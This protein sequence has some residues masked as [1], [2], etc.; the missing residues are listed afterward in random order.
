MNNKI[1]LRR[2]VAH[3]AAVLLYTSQEKEY[4]QAKNK[5]AQNLGIRVLPTNREVAKE[6]DLIAEE[7]EGL[8]RKKRL[9]KL[10]GEALEIMETL[11]IFFPKIVG[12]VWRGTAHKNSD[13]DI[14]A[15]SQDPYQ[16]ISKLKQKGFII[17]KIERKKITNKGEK[18]FSLHITTVFPTGDEAE[19][20]VR[21]PEEITQKEKCEIYGD[22]M[23]GLKIGQL[24]KVLKENPLQKF[25]PKK[26]HSLRY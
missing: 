3:E 18:K 24:K 26:I 13:I 2:K 15:Y 6:I 11:K 9:I 23:E 14:A 20:V 5:A 12:S 17:E 7:S 22:L 1:F 19:I 16:V 4:K 8:K 10:R 21:N 25:L